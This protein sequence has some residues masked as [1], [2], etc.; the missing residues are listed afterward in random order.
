[1]KK[2]SDF[3]SNDIPRTSIS[4]G[5]TIDVEENDSSEHSNSQNSLD[6]GSYDDSTG[7]S[8]EKSDQITVKVCSIERISSPIHFSG[9]SFR[10]KKFEIYLNPMQRMSCV[11]IHSSITKKIKLLSQSN[12]QPMTSMMKKPERNHVSLHLITIK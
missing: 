10:S 1:M 7:I 12:H 3:Q 9:N 4:E 2:L 11:D 8:N 6:D 5:I